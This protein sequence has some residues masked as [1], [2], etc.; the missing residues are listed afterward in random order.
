MTRGA[1]CFVSKAPEEQ[2]I[3]ESHLFTQTEQPDG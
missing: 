2:Q 3:Y 1:E